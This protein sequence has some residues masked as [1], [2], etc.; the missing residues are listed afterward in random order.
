M[1]LLEGSLIIDCI[2][3]IMNSERMV[4]ILTLRLTIMIL[5]F[6]FFLMY[7]VSSSNSICSHLYFYINSITRLLQPWIF[8]LIL[9]FWRKIERRLEGL[10]VALE[11]SLAR[12][13]RSVWES[14]LSYSLP[15][16]PSHDI[17]IWL[18][19]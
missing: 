11:N 9:A 14:K 12:S 5:N 1:L 3:Y 8:P 10:M 17:Q 13:H 2:H 7:I 6:F 16:G 15:R 19:K 18:V 4:N